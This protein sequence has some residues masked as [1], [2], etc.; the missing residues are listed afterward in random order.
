MD[1]VTWEMVE[2][3]GFCVILFWIVAISFA[4]LDIIN[5]YKDKKNESPNNK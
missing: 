2:A 5:C 1:F 3:V 4:I